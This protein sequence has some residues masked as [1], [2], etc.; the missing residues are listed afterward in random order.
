MP[1]R[2]GARPVAAARAVSSSAHWT[3]VTTVCVG[4][5]RCRSSPTVRGAYHSGGTSACAFTHE[6]VSQTSTQMNR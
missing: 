6:V 1:S 3:T 4:V 5:G 2:R